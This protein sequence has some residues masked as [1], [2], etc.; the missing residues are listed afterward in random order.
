MPVG[1][2]DLMQYL[3]ALEGLRSQGFPN[4]PITFKRFEI[5]QSF[6]ERVR[7]LTLRRELA[8]IYTSETY[9]I[10]PPSVESFRFT[11]RQYQGYPQNSHNPMIPAMPRG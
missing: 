6:I 2:E 3:N 5:R 7:D 11:I 9:V 8:N 1:K 10:D 4:E